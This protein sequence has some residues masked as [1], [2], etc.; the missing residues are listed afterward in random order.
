VDHGNVGEGVDEK[1]RCAVGG[2]MD[3]SKRVEVRQGRAPAQRL[4]D[5]TLP[6]D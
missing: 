3:Q 1:T 5:T 4:S 2:T 6:G